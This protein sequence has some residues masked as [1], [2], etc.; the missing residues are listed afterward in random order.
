[1]DQTQV[2]HIAGG[3]FISWATREAHKRTQ[4]G[5]LMSSEIKL[6]NRRNTLP[7]RLKLLNQAEILELKNSVNEMKNS[8]ENIVENIAERVDHMEERIS[9]LDDKHLKMIHIKKWKGSNI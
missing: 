9:E 2:S 8:W 6:M 4:K 5:N 3:F 1:M 7:K